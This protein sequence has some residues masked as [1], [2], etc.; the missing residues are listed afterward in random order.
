MFCVF[1]VH[2]FESLIVCCTFKFRVSNLCRLVF[3]F[4][5]MLVVYHDVKAACCLR[6]LYEH[7]RGVT[8]GMSSK[9]YR[10]LTRS[11]EFSGWRGTT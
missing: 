8:L 9:G 1:L 5:S 10:T 4:M 2:L 11:A 3:R 7:V 6:A